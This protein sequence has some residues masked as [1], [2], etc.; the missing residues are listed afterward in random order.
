MASLRISAIRSGTKFWSSVI[1]ETPY[2]LCSIDL[3][4]I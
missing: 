4:R 3:V 2:D 1:L